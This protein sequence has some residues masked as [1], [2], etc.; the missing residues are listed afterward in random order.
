[1]NKRSIA[2]AFN[3][4][5]KGQ[6]TTI[7]TEEI[8]LAKVEIS[9]AEEMNQLVGKYIDTFLTKAV[10]KKIPGL[11]AIVNWPSGDAPLVNPTVSRMEVF[12]MS[13]SKYVLLLRVE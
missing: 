7:T 4:A 1:M 13:A 12:R 11:K 2:K 3:E 6:W 8:V 5:P 9:S 10:Q